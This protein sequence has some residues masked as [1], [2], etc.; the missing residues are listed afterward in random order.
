[1]ISR[2]LLGDL[3]PEAVLARR[4]HARHH[5][6]VHLEAVGFGVFND[7][8]PVMS[9]LS[10]SIAPGWSQRQARQPGTPI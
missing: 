2:Q 5:A 10:H 8:W 3:D 9:L 4:L 1:M 6:R 7:P